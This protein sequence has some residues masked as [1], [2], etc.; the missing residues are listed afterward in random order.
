MYLKERL[1]GRR[2]GKFI[3]VGVGQGYL[4]AC[5]LS[6]GWTGTGY[7]VDAESAA[8]AIDLNQAAIDDGRYRVTQGNWLDAPPAPVDLIVSSMVL[9]HLSDEDEARYLERCR[10]QVSAGG[11]CILFVPGSPADWGVE[12]E[13]AG[14]Y[15]RYG[16]A[17]LRAR[18]EGA[19]CRVI[20]LAGLS[21]PLSNWL[22]PLSNYLVQRAEGR[23]RGLTLEQR[24]HASGRREVTG[25][26]RFP[27]VARL[28]LNESVLYPFHLLQKATGAARRALVIY[29]EFEPRH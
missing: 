8:R 17:P 9:E 21:Y 19:G 5:L 23:K 1:R 24:T 10:A 28:L 26:T 12:D 18:V 2:P 15:R 22:L 14:H 16:Y 7:E 25:K 11:L 6:A 20:H 29:C 3:E 13:I 27:G 4:S